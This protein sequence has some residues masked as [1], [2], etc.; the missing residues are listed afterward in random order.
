MKE[1]KEES[2]KEGTERHEVAV[3]QG[4]EGTRKEGRR[5]KEK[6]SGSLERKR[7]EEKSRTE[8][9][10][11]GW[12]LWSGIRQEER[13]ECKK[14]FG[15]EGRRR[16]KERRDEEREGNRDNEEK[17]KER[18]RG[19]GVAK[20]KGELREGGYGDVIRR[21]GQ[22]KFVD[23]LEAARLETKRERSASGEAKKEK[24]E[25]VEKKKEEGKMYG[26]G[27]GEVKEWE[28]KAKKRKDSEEEG[29]VGKDEVV[30]RVKRG[31]G[32]AREGGVKIS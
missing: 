20:M 28:E 27:K 4:V 31:G 10:V 5:R 3:K 1:G 22:K 32:G 17:G 23:R 21:V 12:E 11:F 25:S 9:G 13:G 29:R 8:N 18:V 6:D 16:M 30:E 14:R 24:Q 7:E 19:T 26:L 2:G 15:G